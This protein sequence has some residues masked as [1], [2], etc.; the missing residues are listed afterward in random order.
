MLLSSF[1]A[2]WLSTADPVSTASNAVDSVDTS[3]SLSG[4]DGGCTSVVSEGVGVEDVCTVTELGP[5]SF[6]SSSAAWK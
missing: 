2:S 4:G 3:D 5:D 1:F 6:N